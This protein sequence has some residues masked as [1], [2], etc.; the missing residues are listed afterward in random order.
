MGR[1]TVEKVAGSYIIKAEGRAI[2]SV[3]KR[4]HAIALIAAASQP[5]SVDALCSSQQRT[6]VSAYGFGRNHGR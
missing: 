4:C 3:E 1:F 2:L 6:P 5:S